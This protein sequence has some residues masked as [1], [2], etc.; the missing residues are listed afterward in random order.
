MSFQRIVDQ[1]A[2]VRTL[3]AAMEKSRIAHAY[4]FVGPSGVGRKLT[5]STFAKSLNC[6]EPRDMDPCGTCMNCHLIDEGKLTLDTRVVECL[7]LGNTRIPE[8][9]TVYHML[10]MT[11]GIA[12]WFDESGN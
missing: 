8:E 4:I 5:A 12:D 11:S 10:T 6:E 7:D 1:P 3:R 2:A 9:A